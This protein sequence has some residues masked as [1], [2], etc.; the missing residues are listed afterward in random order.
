MDLFHIYVLD[1][2]IILPI[3]VQKDL[4]SHSH[5]LRPVLLYDAVK[6]TQIELIDIEADVDWVIHWATPIAFKSG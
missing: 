2:A 4:G 5:Y 1:R 3:V 6:R